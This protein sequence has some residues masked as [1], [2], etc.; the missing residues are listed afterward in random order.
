MEGAYKDA[1]S[2]MQSLLEIRKKLEDTMKLNTTEPNDSGSSDSRDNHAEESNSV[3]QDT[4]EG[5]SESPATTDEVSE[6]SGI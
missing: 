6:I 5:F 2:R 3:R 4:N 1:V